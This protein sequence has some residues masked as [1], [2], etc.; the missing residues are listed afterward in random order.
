MPSSSFPT[1][2]ELE[3]EFEGRGGQKITE[4]TVEQGQLDTGRGGQ[5]TTGPP[6]SSQWESQAFELEI[7]QGDQEITDPIVSSPLSSAPP[8][9]A[10]SP[11]PQHTPQPR[12]HSTTSVANQDQSSPSPQYSFRPIPILEV[13]F[14]SPVST[15]SDNGLDPDYVPPEGI[16]VSFQHLP[17]MKQFFTY[18]TQSMM[19]QQ[20]QE[21]QRTMST[22]ELD[23]DKWEIT[24][25]P[26]GLQQRFSGSMPVVR[27][28]N[29]INKRPY[30][31][32]S[33]GA[34]EFSH[35][36]LIAEAVHELWV[37]RELKQALVTQLQ[38]FQLI[39]PA[40]DPGLLSY[41]K[42]I[43]PISNLTQALT[44]ARV[45]SIRL[46]LYGQKLTITP[47][48]LANDP[49]EASH[50]L[51]RWNV[52]DIGTTVHSP[53]IWLFSPAHGSH[54][55]IT[56]FAMVS[57]G[58][59]GFGSINVRTRYNNRDLTIKV[60]PTLVHALK[61]IN[62][63]IQSKVPTTLAGLRAAKDT[64]LA[65]IN[66]LSD[67]SP[68]Q[69]G[70]FRMEV[71]LEAKTLTEAS[72]FVR[73]SPFLNLEFWLNPMPAAYNHL[74]LEAKV[75][76]KETLM[77]NTNWV[78]EH[79][80]KS[81]VLKGNN[82]AKPKPYQVQGMVDLLASFGWNVGLR[83]VSK[84]GMTPS[85]WKKEEP[86]NDMLLVL[87]YINHNFD[88]LALKYQLFHKIRDARPGGIKHVPCIL[89]PKDKKHGYQ[90]HAKT[91]F[92]LRC[93]LAS[94]HN[95]MAAP[96][97]MRWFAELVASKQ[98]S[99]EVIGMPDLPTPKGVSHPF[100]PQGASPC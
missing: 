84:P 8:S 87:D 14:S 81:D 22:K 56:L 90:K 73:N 18:S 6:V 68:N 79:I 13:P 71:T 44:D 11:S 77:M 2:H 100:P 57:P 30:D 61:S 97:A 85:W 99:T 75:L 74:K 10:L 72:D 86:V 55:D 37:N 16:P 4:P 26:A 29:H 5:K 3:E 59:G 28:S 31:S 96:K 62:S 9:T 50:P 39:Q 41:G 89:H 40:K 34:P 36:M 27:L 83:R 94:C 66:S 91:S 93:R 60:Y 35:F 78:F 12:S 1:S 53:F 63:Q 47:A 58:S 25:T 20:L 52:W 32:A 42:A 46:R 24:L 64:S 69:L 45:N 67:I 76:T 51:A 82:S 95:S 17:F 80:G 88:T 98:V 43:F 48:L 49:G 33:Q 21:I 15:A 65:V 7:E 92:K 38:K 23:V 19:P 70:G 54:P